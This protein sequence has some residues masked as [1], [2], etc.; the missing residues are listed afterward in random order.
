M[1]KLVIWIDTS[2]NKSYSCVVSGSQKELDDLHKN[3]DVILVKHGR[4][5][6]FHWRTLRRNIRKSAQNEII[7]LL[8]ESKVH[9]N[10][11]EHKP[12][13]TVNDKEFYL[14]HVPNTISGSLDKWLEGKA[15]TVLV[16]VDKD[17]LVKEV[18]NSTKLFVANLIKR[19]CERL[20]GPVKLRIDDAIRADLKHTNGN[21][22]QFIGLVSSRE[23]SKD[24]QL[25]DITLGYYLY[26]KT[27]LEEKVFFKKI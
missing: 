19:L 11:F 13:F 21:V 22:M 9:F 3:V 14:K 1:V 6:T 27:A 24:I 4:K 26:D 20:V 18:K 8:K 12:A 15:G 2:Q 10:I 5:G 7:Q 16:H 17:Y 25:A 23:L